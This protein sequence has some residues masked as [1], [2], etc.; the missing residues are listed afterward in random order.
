MKIL[1]DEVTG[2]V[3]WPLQSAASLISQF[4][5]VPQEA[6]ISAMQ[7]HQRY[8]PVVDADGKFA[9]VFYCDK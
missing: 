9:A 8:F 5:K 4:L 7:D 3:E 6:L 2:L 1:L